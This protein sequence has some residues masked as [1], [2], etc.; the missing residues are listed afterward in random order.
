MLRVKLLK[1]WYNYFKNEKYQTVTHT[2]Y[3]SM[4]GL[5]YTMSKNLKNVVLLKQ[6]KETV[7]CSFNQKTES[8]CACKQPAWDRKWSFRHG[9]QNRVGDKGC[10]HNF[11]LSCILQNTFNVFRS[12]HLRDTELTTDSEPREKYNFQ[13]Y[14]YDLA[15]QLFEYANCLD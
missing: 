7:F 1:K 9:G 14:C 10:Q 2:C 3:K 12:F 13:Q 8:F 11:A 5:P 15:D 4:L 6:L